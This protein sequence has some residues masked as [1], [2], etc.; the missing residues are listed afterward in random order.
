MSNDVIRESLRS[1]YIPSTLEPTGL[2]RNDGR[3]PDGVTM[4]PWSRG[5]YL[6]WDFTCVQRL[7]T[8]HLSKGRQESSSVATAK[9]AI[10][11]QHCND[12]PSCYTLEPVA[13]ETLGDSSSDFLRKLAKRILEQ[14]GEK[15]FFAWL[16]QHLSIAVQRENATCI[17]ESIPD[18]S[19]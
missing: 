11:R 18:S 19:N 5:R 17:L 12:I 13:I 16:R 3:H 4:L 10:K 1:G 8:S 2:M 15:C 9:E 6:A 7:A 14:T